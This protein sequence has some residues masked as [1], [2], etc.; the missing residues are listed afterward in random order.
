MKLV[1]SYQKDKCTVNIYDDG[2]GEYIF[3][4]LGNKFHREDGP[5]IEYP[6]GSKYWFLHGKEYFV[7]S[8]DE[9]II[10]RIIE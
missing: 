6:N 8:V 5:A 7:N 2:Y 4:F 9:L 10:A 1:R 3:Y